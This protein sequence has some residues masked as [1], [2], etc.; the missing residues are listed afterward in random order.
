MIERRFK[1]AA[2]IRVR[3]GAAGDAGGAA[4]MDRF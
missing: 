3:F 2:T 1:K 4:K